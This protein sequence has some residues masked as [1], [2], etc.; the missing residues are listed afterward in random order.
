MCGHHMISPKFVEYIVR[1]V[2]QGRLTPEEG[3][4]KL[5]AFCY[6][7]IFNQVRCARLLE[8]HKEEPPQG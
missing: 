6:C 5:A 7:G 1:Q 3:A 4:L 2:K 8:S